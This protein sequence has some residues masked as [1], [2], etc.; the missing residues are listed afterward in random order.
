MLRHPN[1]RLTPKGRETPVSRIES[2]EGVSSVARQAGVGRRTASKWPRR[3]RAGEALSDR[4]SRPRPRTPR[5]ARR[6]RGLGCGPGRGAGASCP[7]VAVDGRS[8]VA[9]AGPLPD[10]GKGTCPAFVSRCLAFFDG[11]GVRVERVVTGSGPGCRSREFN[12]P[13]GSE[14]VR[15]KYARPHSPWQNGKVERMNRTP[16][17]GRRYGGAGAPPAYLERCNCRRPHSAC[18]GL[19]PMSRIVGV[20]NLLAHNN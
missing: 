9:Y 11:L 10:E 20:N 16:A 18:E 4:S 3:P 5:S 6:A 14:G 2:G 7:R 1:A 12:S 17:Q 13:L 19:P 15:H 8:R